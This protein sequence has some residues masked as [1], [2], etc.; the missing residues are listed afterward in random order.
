M[1]IPTAHFST[2]KSVLPRLA[3]ARIN[4]Q[5]RRGNSCCLRF[6]DSTSSSVPTDGLRMLIPRGRATEAIA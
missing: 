5:S 2:P 1:F 3:G 6:E 4:L